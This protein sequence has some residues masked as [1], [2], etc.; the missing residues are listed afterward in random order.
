[1]GVKALELEVGMGDGNGISLQHAPSL[2]QSIGRWQRIPC[3]FDIVICTP[4]VPKNSCP[5]VSPTR[6]S[7]IHGRWIQIYGMLMQFQCRCLW[8]LLLCLMYHHRSRAAAAAAAI[9]A[10]ATAAAATAV[11]AAP[12]L[13]QEQGQGAAKLKPKPK[14]KPNSQ[15]ERQSAM[16][17]R[18]HGGLSLLRCTQSKAM[19]E[20]KL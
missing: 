9:A 20:P 18:S 1:V 7:Q 19:S 15:R 4:L 17:R 13:A 2:A 16:R 11:V 3:H 6:T 14:A 10:L 8:I 12:S 5:P